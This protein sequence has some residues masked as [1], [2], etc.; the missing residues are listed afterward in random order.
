MF[1]VLKKTPWP[2]VSARMFTYWDTCFLVF[3][4]LELPPANRAPVFTRYTS[5]TRL[6]AT[7]R[8]I[9]MKARRRTKFWVHAK[10]KD[11][12]NESDEVN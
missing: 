5:W 6:S 9:H 8:S 1:P 4:T 7:S 11:Q 12:S 10:Q 3:W 2:Q